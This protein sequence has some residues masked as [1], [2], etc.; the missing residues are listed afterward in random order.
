MSN[1]LYLH[2]PFCA[3]K[4]AYC[5]FFS[6]IRTPAVRQQYVDMLQKQLHQATLQ[7]LST[8]YIGGGTPSLL[9][10]AQ[11]RAIFACLPAA[12]EVTFEVNPEHVTPDYI[13]NLLAC[14]V[15][16]ISMGVQSFCTQELQALGRR[17]TID[18]CKQAMDII[19][20]AGVQNLSIDLMLATPQQTAQSLKQ[21]LQTVLAYRPQH[22]SA[23]LLKVE[24]HSIYGKTN[25]QEAGE[26][27]QADRY[28]QAAHFLAD[29][30]Y[31]HYE[32]SNFALPG[33]RARHNS[34]YWT[35]Q[36]YLAFGAGA[37]GFDGCTRYHYDKNIDR[38]IR[39]P[40]RIIDEASVDKKAEQLL[41]RIRT[42]DGLEDLNAEQ[43]A[44]LQTL[45]QAGLAA[46]TARG[47]RLTPS[48]WLV[49]NPILLKLMELM[50][51]NE[52][53]FP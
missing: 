48:G 2:I 8:I 23:Y 9:T 34:A 51:G 11:V 30:G 21:T 4:C 41:L 10:Q 47:Y 37:F 26:E 53:F 36:S 49:C 35:G 5:G 29:H 15:N 27:Q 31:E 16:R 33:Y 22:V 32:I 1:G 40:Q 39:A 19:R 3:H 17:A 46:K 43:T 14:G 18:K 6:Q 12:Q 42:A 20:Q 7:N 50:Y 38:Y 44:F 52:H 25:V 45:Q 13:K 28:L 24:P